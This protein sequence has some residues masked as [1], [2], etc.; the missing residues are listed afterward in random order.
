MYPFICRTA[1][2]IE[3]DF[4]AVVASFRV[5]TLR[6]FPTHLIPL[7]RGLF[8]KTENQSPLLGRPGQI[9]NQP[10]I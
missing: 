1:R 10:M 9:V 3:I 5:P 6:Q 8:E 4:Y 2:F 7:M